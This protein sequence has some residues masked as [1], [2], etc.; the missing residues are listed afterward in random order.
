M[1]CHVHLVMENNS[2]QFLLGLTKGKGGC[3]VL[4]SN[5]VSFSD[6]RRR[7]SCT[8][9]H[10][11]KQTTKVSKYSLLASNGHIA[12]LVITNCDR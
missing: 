5:T 12:D 8:T 11:R 2:G 3:V 6:R 1:T 10:L 7:I 4:L 9:Q